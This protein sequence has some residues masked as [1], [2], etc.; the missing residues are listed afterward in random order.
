MYK[1][2]WYRW[3]TAVSISSLEMKLGRKPNNSS[4]GD[5]P[6][7]PR[8][9]V[10]KSWH[11]SSEERHLLN[12]YLLEHD[13]LIQ[14]VCGAYAYAPQWWRP[15]AKMMQP[16]GVVDL[17]ALKGRADIAWRASSE[18]LTEW[19][20]SFLSFGKWSGWL[21]MS[22]CKQQL[23]KLTTSKVEEKWNAYTTSK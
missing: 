10:Q 22:S 11:R 1:A 9:I 13:S 19:R 23:E 21:I 17:E 18:E 2:R 7:A 12:N 6:E 15:D 20:L 4:L 16:N 14:T 8:A 3:I 5:Y